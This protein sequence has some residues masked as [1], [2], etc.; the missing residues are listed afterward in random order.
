[1]SV[2]KDGNDVLRDVA[3]D[4]GLSAFGRGFVAG[5]L[6]NAPAT[7]LVT[8]PWVNSYKRLVPGYE[9]PTRCTWARHNW[10]D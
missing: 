4:N 1:M 10:D 9:A 8:N 5:L 7:T 3:D 6:A 2:L